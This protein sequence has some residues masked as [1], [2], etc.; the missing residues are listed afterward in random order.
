MNPPH[1]SVSV[2][3][4]YNDPAVRQQCLDRS[5]QAL[6]AEASNVEYLPVD[7]V[8]GAYRSAGAAL[9]HG[10]SLASNEVIVFVHQDVFLHSLDALKVAAG[11]MLNSDFG[12]L[13]AIGIRS[14]S[15]MIGR[16]RDRVLL[17]GDAVTSLTE[18]DSLDEVLFMAPRSQLLREPLTDSHQL[19]WHA[20]AVE[21]GLRVR[22]IGLKVGVADIP[23]THNSLSTNLD[24][25]DVAH[26]EVAA[27]YA[28]FLPIWTTCGIIT[29][30]TSKRD[31]KRWLSSHRWRYRWMRDSFTLLGARGGAGQMPRVIAD[32]RHDVDSIIDRSP[33]QR[34]HII[35]CSSD[36]RFAHGRP[37]LLELP[38]RDGRAVF[39]AC[40]ISDIPAALSSSPPGAWIL[41]TNLSPAELKLLRSG[42][43]SMPVVLGFHGGTGL[44][45]L[46][47]APSKDLPP[48]WNSRR[49]T[50]LGKRARAFKSSIQDPV[51][52]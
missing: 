10:V 25:L 38:R 12:L 30:K 39:T 48:Q 29:T 22:R 51:R 11:E 35:N 5:I 34:L 4:V 14:D 31:G 36:S 7:N 42:L 44:W 15:R 41:V 21:Y 50:P 16:I 26:Q 45:L 2:V 24:R 1:A 27:R 6:N 49:A 43:P 8:H 40:G 20:Y 9:N 23:L 18:A 19:A 37:D 52:A 28:D 13:G 17:T 3:C 33:D 47:G 32:I 46:V